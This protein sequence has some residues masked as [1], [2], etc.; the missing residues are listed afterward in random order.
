MII[1]LEY[2]LPTLSGI[3]LERS[4][5]ESSTSTEFQT[6]SSGD[7]SLRISKCSENSVETGR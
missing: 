4:S 2:D 7:P 1:V 6:T 5:L 3:R